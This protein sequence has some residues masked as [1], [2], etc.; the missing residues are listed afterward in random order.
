MRTS[1]AFLRS[2]SI[3]ASS[4]AATA[5]VRAGGSSG[6]VI[7]A[8]AAATGTT[9]SV[10]MSDTYCAG[11]IHVTVSGTSPSATTVFTTA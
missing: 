4:D 3:T 10:D 7:L 9:A 11:G 5:T 8:L 2:V 6:T 1:N